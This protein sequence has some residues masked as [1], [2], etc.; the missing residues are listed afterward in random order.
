MAD[1]VV[2]GNSSGSVTLRAPDV[3][4]T[5]ILTLPTTTGTLVVT[6]GAQTVQFAAGSAAAPSITFT[7]DTNTGI[8]SP[9]ADTIAFSEGGVESMRIDASGNVGIG[10]SSPSADL[11]ILRGNEEVRIQLNN[12]NSG[13]GTTSGLAFILAAD[14]VTN[15]I[16]AYES[17]A[18]VNVY[19]NG[20]T[21][22]IT[23]TYGIGL[24][25]SSAPTS[26]MGIRFP[27]T[28]SASSDA[29]TLDDYEEGTWTPTVF[30]STTAGT[31]TIIF[32]N[33]RYRKIGSQVTVWGDVQFSAATG[34]AGNVRIGNL[35]FN[36]VSG[37]GAVPGVLFVDTVNTTSASSIGSCVA[38]T[39]GAS[40]NEI[41][42]FL[43]IDNASTEQIP[44][45]GVS[46]SSRF[47]FTY[48]YTA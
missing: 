34:G 18:T 14:G 43:L 48:T 28:Q 17:A 30:G 10:T 46:T 6:G 33:S 7:G 39:T 15:Y 29:N 21:R 3:S 44:I 26:G 38:A 23:N 1:I 40:S 2:S 31:Y 22:T 4:G 13:T 5:T 12:T 27:A 20:E 19:V 24:G 25:N 16:A 41:F 11:D 37:T 47:A 35:P 9:G 8:F 32:S 45:S 36:Y 42:P